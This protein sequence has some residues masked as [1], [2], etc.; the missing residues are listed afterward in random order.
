MPGSGT[1]TTLVSVALALAR[2]ADHRRFHVHGVADASAQLRAL[3]G[4]PQVGTIVDVD[5]VRRQARLIRMLTD[6]LDARRA[7]PSAPRP[8]I[9]VLID[10]LPGLLRRFD[11]VEGHPISD[12][13]HQVFRDGPPVGIHLA[14]TCDRP[15][16]IPSAL[17]SRTTERLVPPARPVRSPVARAVAASPA[18]QRPGRG[19]PARLRYRCRWRGAPTSLPRSEA[20]ERRTPT[21]VLVDRPAVIGALHDLGASDLPPFAAHRTASGRQALHRRSA[22][23]PTAP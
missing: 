4:L 17:A 5:D 9:V 15:G 10:D 12:G 23:G 13:L 11:T 18:R 2:R 3:T 19:D 14:V 20:E 21:G 8:I 22:S 7:A 6:E 1:T 16:A